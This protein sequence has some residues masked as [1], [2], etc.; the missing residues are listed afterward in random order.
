MCDLDQGNLSARRAFETRNGNIRMSNSKL[1][2]D[3]IITGL[4]RLAEEIRSQARPVS[5]DR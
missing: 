4:R 2:L 1:T 3:D 5:P